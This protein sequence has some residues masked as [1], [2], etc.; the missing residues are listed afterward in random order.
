MGSKFIETERV[1]TTVEI[2]RT[3]GSFLIASFGSEM[4]GRKKK[5]C[6]KK[7]TERKPFHWR[8]ETREKSEE[9]ATR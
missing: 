1:I 2:E 6:L 7:E 5:K 4:P 8:S 9:N 3:R